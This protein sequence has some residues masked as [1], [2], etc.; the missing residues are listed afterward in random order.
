[1]V[2]LALAPLGLGGLLAA[3]GWMP[4]R[5]DPL[6]QAVGLVPAVILSLFYA[7]QVELNYGALSYSG[8]PATLRLLYGAA[9]LGV[10]DNALSGA[11][12]GTR[13]V[14]EAELRQ[15][16]VQMALLRGESAIANALPNVL[17]S[18][19]GQFRA[20]TLHLLSGAVVVEVV[21]GIP[22]IG[23]LLFDG[24][25]LQDFGVVLAATWAFS[26]FSA[27]LLLTQ[28]TLEILIAL[29]IR[30]YPAGALRVE[31]GA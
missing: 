23:E 2:A 26:L 20:R 27:A 17:P 7:A 12:I 31:G 11:I 18:L 16:Y 30:R 1:L 13:S 5:L 24:T 25:L 8:W 10:A 19:I 6:W 9:I 15:R 21:M 4:R 28:G 3:V 29:W 22:G 14:F